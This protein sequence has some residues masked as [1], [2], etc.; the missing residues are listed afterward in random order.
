MRYL[1]SVLRGRGIFR[2]QQVAVVVE[3]A[4]DRNGDSHIGEP[5]GDLGNCCGS[6]VVVDRDADEP[7]SGAREIR[8]L[9]RGTG[10]I[11]R[12]GVRH[13]LHDDRMGGPYGDAA[14]DG[15]YGLSSRYGGQMCLRVM[16]LKANSLAWAVHVN[17]ERLPYPRI[18]WS[19]D[20]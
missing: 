11:G 20:G 17:Q 14:D 3:V 5:A 9:E 19:S 8:D 7:A 1:A 13:R 18:P 12:V 4:D 2:E 15:G 6:F 10:G 16:N